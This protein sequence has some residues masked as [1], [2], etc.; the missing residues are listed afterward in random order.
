MAKITTILF[1]I[2][3]AIIAFYS[4]VYVL[5]VFLLLVAY[6]LIRIFWFKLKERIRGNNNDGN[7]S[8]RKNKDPKNTVIDVDYE[9]I[10]E[11]QLSDSDENKG[12]DNK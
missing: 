10:E 6:F 5:V 4:F 1:L 7:V 3:A 8:Y 12:E 2:L 9:I 11:N